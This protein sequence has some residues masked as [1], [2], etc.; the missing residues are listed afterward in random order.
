MGRTGVSIHPHET[1]TTD[2][3]EEPCGLRWRV[4][5]CAR[6]ATATVGHVYDSV[7]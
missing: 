1:V 7:A 3:K 2:E 4:L 5:L 6:D